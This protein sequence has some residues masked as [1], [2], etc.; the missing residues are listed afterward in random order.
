MNPRVWCF[1]LEMNKPS[2]KIIQVG[3]VIGDLSKGRILTEF[4]YYINPEE[5]LDPFI[6]GLTGIT[7]V[8][9]D[10][11]LALGPV[12]RLVDE[13]ITKYKACKSPVVWGNGDLRTLKAQGGTGYFQDIHREIDIKTISQFI[14]LSKGLSMRGGL[15]KSLTNFGLKFVGTPHNA[16]DD[17]KNTFYLACKLQKVLKECQIS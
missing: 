9:V 14:S 3:G 7:Q 6:I 8:Q 11:G 13:L 15:E 2:N 10:Q 12:K 17:A 16:L 4:N 1:D 5:P